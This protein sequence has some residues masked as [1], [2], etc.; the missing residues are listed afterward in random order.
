VPQTSLAGRPTFAARAHA[1]PQAKAWRAIVLAGSIPFLF[2]HSRFQPDY[3]VAVGSTT[4]D[5][6]LADVAIAIVLVG[7]LVAGIREGFE[8]LR[9]GRMLWLCGAGLL[10]W[11]AFETLRP[12]SLRDAVFADHA[13]SALKLAEYASLALAVPLLVRRASDVAIVLWALI[14][15]STIAVAVALLQFFGLDAFEASSA[16]WRYPSFLGRHDFAALCVPAVSLAI[17][18][19]LA[20]WARRERSWLFALALTSGVVGLVLAGSVT[21]AGGLVLGAALATGAARRRFTPSP[22]ELLAVLAVVVAV[23]LGVV[24]IRSSTINDFLGFVGIRQHEQVTGVES[25]S[26][27]TVLAYIGLRIFEDRPLLGA[28]WQRSSQP[29][30][31]EPYL[32]DAHRRFPDVVPLAFP[33]PEHPWGVQNLYVQTLADMGLV[34]FVLLLA[35]GAS[36]LVLAWRTAGHASTSWAVGTGLLTLCALLTLGGTWASLGLVPG[37]PLQAATSLVLG[38]AAAGAAT[39]EDETRG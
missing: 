28:G 25:Y 4:V 35:L 34:G 5:I 3:A 39:V 11:V 18:C 12:T 6:R 8:P 22:R 26:Q 29:S 36:G 20:A 1:R 17:G 23:A 15:W 27:R 24:A 10:A 19:L 21:A 38:L 32:P 16:G 9:A 13:V 30:V 33:S 37:I 2:L 7:A 31:F 14:G